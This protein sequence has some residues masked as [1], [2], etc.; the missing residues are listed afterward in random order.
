MA[1]PNQSGHHRLK[2]IF[3]AAG[4]G[5]ERKEMKG[6]VIDIAP[7]ILRLF[8]FDPPAEMDGKCLDIFTDRS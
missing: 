3:M 8:G 4:P 6:E 1:T 7:T 2:G 5:I